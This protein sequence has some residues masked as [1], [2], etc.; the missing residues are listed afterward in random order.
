MPCAIEL[1]ERRV[2]LAAQLNHHT[3]TCIEGSGREAN[4]WQRNSASVTWARAVGASGGRERWA[5]GQRARVRD[6]VVLR[7]GVGQF[8]K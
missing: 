3:A 2:C 4:E 7:L 8:V 6:A 5:R 1:T